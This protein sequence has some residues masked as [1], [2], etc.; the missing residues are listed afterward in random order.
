[1]LTASCSGRPRSVSTVASAGSPRLS[2][3]S[4][5]FENPTRRYPS[6]SEKETAPDQ[7][8]VTPAIVSKPPSKSST[9]TTRVSSVAS[10][11]L[12]APAGSHP[13]A[14]QAST[15][16]GPIVPESVESAIMTLW[17][18]GVGPGGHQRY[19]AATGQPLEDRRG[20][21]LVAVLVPVGIVA[22]VEQ[23]GLRDRPQ[24]RVEVDV[25]K[26]ELRRQAPQVIG[27]VGLLR[28][29]RET[30]ELR[31]VEAFCTG[32]H[33]HHHLET[34]VVR[35]PPHFRERRVEM[36]AI[37]MVQDVRL[38]ALC[39][40]DILREEELVAVD[41]GAVER[42]SDPYPVHQVR[43]R[44]AAR[45]SRLGAPGTQGLLEEYVRGRVRPDQPRKL[46]HAI[47][48]SQRK[49]RLRVLALGVDHVVLVF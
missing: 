30:V 1:M 47:R 42:V 14:A 40:A 44:A 10:R 39:R 3:W 46:E 8:A 28:Q 22:Q 5:L 25:G 36:A 21:M 9:K 49:P 41:F 15:R 23:P 33:G 6:T 45:P 19:A 7:D 20:R 38:R 2:L 48:E 37:R 34:V 27:E 11:L 35:H 13:A 31:A 18:G 17:S 12:V 32:R 4:L 24:R 16:T 43:I 29:L 26:A